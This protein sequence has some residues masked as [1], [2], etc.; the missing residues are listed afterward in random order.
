MPRGERRQRHE[1]RATPLQLERDEFWLNRFDGTSL[2]PLW[3]KV[4]R[5]K[6]PRRMR[7]FYSRGSRH[8]V[9]DF[10]SW[11]HPL[12]RITSFDV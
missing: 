6:A 1:E 8:N 10:R 4:A 5:S 12:T 9:K 11:K 7:G 2:L 3:E